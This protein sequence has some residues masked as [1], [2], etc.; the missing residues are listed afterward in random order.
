MALRPCHDLSCE[1]RWVATSFFRIGGVQSGLAMAFVWLALRD[2]GSIGRG[3][4]CPEDI[5]CIFFLL[6]L[7]VVLCCF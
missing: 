4:G 6:L 2:F 5:L 3:G 7:C 1:G